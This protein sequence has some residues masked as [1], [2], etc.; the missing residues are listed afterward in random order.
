MYWLL[1]FWTKEAIGNMMLAIKLNPHS[2]VQLNYCNWT[3]NVSVGTGE[4][5]DKVYPC[6]LNKNVNYIHISREIGN[7]KLA[8]VWVFKDR[9]I[10]LMER[11][12][13]PVKEGGW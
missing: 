8:K 4:S 12:N 11:L 7:S 3:Q 6:T 10:S 13:Y 2:R 1:V 5:D 9:E